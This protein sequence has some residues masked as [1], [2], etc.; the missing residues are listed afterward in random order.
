MR[1]PMQAGDLMNTPA[2]DF[3]LFH[4]LTDGGVKTQRKEA[5]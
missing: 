2:I 4:L 1:T 3:A 5:M